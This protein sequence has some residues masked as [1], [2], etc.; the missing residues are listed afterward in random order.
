MPPDSKLYLQD[1]RRSVPVVHFGTQE[2][3]GYHNFRSVSGRILVGA[4]TP[5][6]ATEVLEEEA[7]MNLPTLNVPAGACADFVKFCREQYVRARA[8]ET[9]IRVLHNRNYDAEVSQIRNSMKSEVDEIF[10]PVEKALRSGCNCREVMAELVKA[11]EYK[12]K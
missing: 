10:A 3:A 7:E 1:N 12:E 5:K 4:M 2:C 11:L 9:F 6:V 8:A